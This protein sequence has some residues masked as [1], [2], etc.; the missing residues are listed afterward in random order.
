VGGPGRLRRGG[1]I[2]SGKVTGIHS[3]K[4][5]PMVEKVTGGLK[6]PKSV[7]RASLI[8]KLL[9]ENQGG[10]KALQSS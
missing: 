3:V 2:I 6:L 1:S 9:K 4:E 5:N 10:M 8:P 7:S